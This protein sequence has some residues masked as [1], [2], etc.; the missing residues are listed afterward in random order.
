MT[1]TA[2]GTSMLQRE[3]NPSMY[4]H[5][6]AL[7]AMLDNLEANVFAADPSFRLVYANRRALQTA[8]TIEPALRAAF[9]V[10]VDELV[11]GSI[12]RFHRDP[13]R[14]ERILSNPA[15]FPHTATFSFGPVTLQTRI[16]G[17]FGP[18]GEH[19][20][21]IVS[22]E[23]VTHQRE[24]EQLVQTLAEELSTAAAR[25]QSS[26]A[27]LASAAERTSEHATSSAGATEEMT[28]S[29][30][31]IA[32]VTQQ[33]VRLVNEVVPAAK[34]SVEAMATLRTRAR[35]IGSIVT[36]INKVADQTNLLALN[37]TIEAARAGEAGRGFAVVAGEIKELSRETT[38]ATSSIE[39]MVTKIQEEAAGA[40]TAIE[41]VTALVEQVGAEQATVAAA[42]EEQTATA[43]EISSAVANV[44]NLAAS[45]SG[46]VADLQQ[47]AEQLAT[48]AD[49]L[50]DLLGGAR[51]SMSS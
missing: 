50:K 18:A 44:A 48:K 9:G 13:A 1:Y 39:E 5:L 31:E 28:A 47:L 23:D 45:T 24:I 10:G 16:N 40:A 12:H 30:R 22:W 14:I 49:E 17:V 36:V 35:E 27:E 2:P 43:S 51:G 46:T 20:G 26:S 32:R 19:Y 6:E 38:G 8:R 42:V 4:E 7:Q 33:A 37:A 15:N 21:F 11:G 3:G 34:S 25:T 29:I 41:Q